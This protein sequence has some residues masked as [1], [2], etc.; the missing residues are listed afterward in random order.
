MLTK[1]VPFS[2]GKKQ[3]G[4]SSLMVAA[5][6]EATVCQSQKIPF[7]P[8]DIKGSFSS[9]INRGLVIRKKVALDNKPEV[10]WQVTPE[11]IAILSSMGV[12]V[13]F[14]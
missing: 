10:L 11:A 8:N 13:M 12:D 5:L 6:V 9:L 2:S 14:N 4:L 1:I 7:G 3:A